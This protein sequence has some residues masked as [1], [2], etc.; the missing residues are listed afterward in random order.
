MSER[1][2]ARS[3]LARG[4]GTLAG[5]PRFTSWIA[6]GVVA[7]ACGRAPGVAV[8]HIEPEYNKS[9][10]RL[11]RLRYDANRNGVVE[12]FSYMD[13]NR[14]L[15]VEIDTDEDGR[16]DR[17]EHYGV[18]GKLERVGF[19]RDDDGRESAWSYADAQ[20]RIV[21]IDV[22]EGDEGRIT[23][24]EFYDRDVLVRSEEDVDGDGAMDKWEQYEGGR[25]T[26]L[27]FDPDHHGRPTHTFSYGSDGALRVE[28]DLAGE[29]RSGLPRR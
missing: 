2:A 11:E 9:T 14:V 7:V 26:R 18:G 10:G 25:L 5:L 4:R 24:R 15:R 1:V 17:W 13:G 12:T 29:S 27:A 8:G 22:A 16:I 19:S 21:R 28:S 3:A 20:G 23:R 6:L